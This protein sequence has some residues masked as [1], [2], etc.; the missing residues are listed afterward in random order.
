MAHV[1]DEGKVGPGLVGIIDS[2]IEIVMDELLARHLRGYETAQGAPRI[3]GGDVA[4]AF[5][6]IGGVAA[7]GID[8]AVDEVARV[9]VG[10]NFGVS[11]ETFQQVYAARRIAGCNESR[12]YVDFVHLRLQWKSQHFA[13]RVGLAESLQRLVIEPDL[14]KKVADVKKLVGDHEIVAYRARVFDNTIDL[15]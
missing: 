14:V 11:F 3:G 9:G 10:H 4:V 13:Q 7:V 12:S 8:I 1:G 6:K 5:G 2:G 15:R